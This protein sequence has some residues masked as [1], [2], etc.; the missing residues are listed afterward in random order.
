MNNEIWKPV[1]GYEGLYEV[2]NLGRVKSI[3]R[4][5]TKGGILSL[6]ERAGYYCVDLSK[7]DSRSTIDVHRLVAKAFIDNQSNL[8]QVNHKDE[9]KHNNHVDNLE[10]CTCKYNINYGTSLQR[11]VETQ[12][13]QRRKFFCHET[14]KTYSSQKEFAKEMGVSVG[15]VNNVLH[16]RVGSRNFVI[17]FID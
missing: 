9:N 2:S 14:G 10:W 16:N 17:K 3:P 1:I 8:P 12:R 4:V 5:G 6:K 13:K 7:N 15:F 11:M